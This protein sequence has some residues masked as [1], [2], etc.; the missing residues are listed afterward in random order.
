LRDFPDVHAV[1]W[2]DGYGMTIPRLA[3][4]T[5]V[6]ALG[7]CAA[8]ASGA[9]PSAS[10]GVIHACYQ[11]P[12]L[13][14]N[15]GAVRVIDAEQGQAC[16]SNETALE[17][18]QRGPKGDTGPQ[19]AKG[20]KG[21]TG[22]T[23]ATGPQGATGSQGATG[24]Q[25]EPGLPGAKGDKGDTGA[26]GPAVA[27]EYQVANGA[28][29]EIGISGRETRTVA[30]LNL[31]A[32]RHAVSAH[33]DLTNLDGDTQSEG[34]SLVGAGFS[35]GR[36]T[37]GPDNLIYERSHKSVSLDSTTTLTGP[38]AVSVE[39]NGFKLFVAGHL[40]ALRIQ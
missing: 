11:K 26:P 28:A 19:G 21:D 6:V 29:V 7:L 23:G 35:G 36:A 8:V 17:W 33:L 16:R 34:C 3:V 13:L 39:C 20:D 10:D 5:A 24:P 31:P 9:I 38:T 37:T 22:A 2:R 12:G 4:T 40:E 15:P 27:P 30:T 25:G 1:A 32:G 14:A 18:S